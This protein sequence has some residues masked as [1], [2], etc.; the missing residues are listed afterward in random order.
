MNELNIMN[1]EIVLESYI[2]KTRTLKACEEI[3]DQMRFLLKQKPTLDIN[4]HPLNKKLC[5]LLK[6][7]FGFKNAYV[8]WFRFDALTGGTTNAY[9]QVNAVVFFKDLGKREDDDSGVNGYYDKKHQ[10]VLCIT[11]STSMILYSDLTGGE[12]LA[13]LLHEIGHNFDNDIHKFF[14]HLINLASS[15]IMILDTGKWMKEDGLRNIL[16]NS[17]QIGELF[18]RMAFISSPL[19]IGSN[20]YNELMGRMNQLLNT[21][22]DIVPFARYIERASI[23]TV[24]LLDEVFL[25]LNEDW[26]VFINWIKEKP[27]RQAM[28][29]SPILFILKCMVNVSTKKGEKYADSFATIYGYGSELSTALTK[30]TFGE[31]SHIKMATDRFPIVSIITDL[32]YAFH[33]VV[34]CA[35]Q[36][37]HGS[38]IERAVFILQTLRKE[39]ASSDLHPGLKKEVE[40][41][42]VKLEEIIDNLQHATIE[43][44]YYIAAGMQ[45]VILNVFK[46]NTFLLERIFP[47][48]TA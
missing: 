43:K 20:I 14:L 23:S 46:G 17:E 25:V 18:G 12:L 44:R 40:E 16:N 47:D 19:I 30:T 10:H 41:E 15:A 3:L 39:L 34:N 27:I 11:I 24:R 13:I 32:R 31:I 35:M 36:P 48:H 38:D 42:I 29:K 26:L 6:Q 2:G 28:A 9:T 37:D 45:W 21:I 1:E 33:Y 22:I 8:N 4:N 7:E 5:N